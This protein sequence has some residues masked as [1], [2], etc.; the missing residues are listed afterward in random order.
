MK[1]SYGRLI[2]TA[3]LAASGSPASEYHGSGKAGGLPYPGVAVTAIQ[4]DRRMVTT[5]DDL[6][7]FHFADL[8]DGT[9]SIEVRTLGFE[10]QVHEVGVSA[11]AAAPEWEPKFLSESAQI[12]SA[13]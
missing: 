9:W 10:P 7:T 11:A 12:G 8:P 4:G 2:L 3:W 1:P 5:T 13:S 6:G